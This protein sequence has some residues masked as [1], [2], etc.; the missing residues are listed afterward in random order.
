MTRQRQVILDELRKV[1][2]HPA[3]DAVYRM[4]RR[5]LPRISLA[6]VY[7]NLE[8]LA[9]AGLIQK[10]ESGGL[11]RRF[12]GNVELH[13]HVRCVRCGRM[14]DVHIGT[15]PAIENALRGACGYEILGYRLTFAGVCPKCRKSARRKK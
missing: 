9:E 6:T 4:V 13:Y 7:R 14:D 12:D 10:L 1:T 5:R 3:A 11:P 2:S 15:L 8:V